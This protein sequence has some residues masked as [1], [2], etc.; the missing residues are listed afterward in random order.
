MRV[1]PSFGHGIPRQ[2]AQYLWCQTGKQSQN[3]VTSLTAVCLGISLDFVVTAILT[4]SF[5]DKIEPGNFVTRQNRCHKAHF[6]TL[7][8][9]DQMCSY[10]ALP[11]DPEKGR[12]TVHKSFH[13]TSIPLAVQNKIWGENQHVFCESTE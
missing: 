9:F 6:K 8:N 1:Q 11:L 13:G 7:L 10:C 4:L 3:A 12:Y 5:L 2:T